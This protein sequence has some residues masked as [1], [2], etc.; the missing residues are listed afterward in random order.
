MKRNIVFLAMLLMIA[1]GN[2][3]NAQET[4]THTET[5]KTQDGRAVRVQTETSTYAGGTFTYSMSNTGPTLV[6]Y[7]VKIEANTS[8]FLLK[9]ASNSESTMKFGASIGGFVKVEVAKGF[10]IQPELIAHYKTSVMK[11]KSSS[12]L[13]NYEYFGVEIPLYYMGQFKLGKGKAYAGLA[14]YF[15]I[16]ISAKYK[17]D[18]GNIINLFGKNDTGANSQMKRFDFGF[19]AQAG[20]EFRCGIQINA[21]YKVGVIDHAKAENISMFPQTVSLGLAYRF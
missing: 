10:L 9:N 21:T 11:D 8:N 5:R 3:I 13:S 19:G 7:G 12:N 1:T 6:S 20:Y 14:P 15:G 16:G 18:D 4:E 2:Q 17:S